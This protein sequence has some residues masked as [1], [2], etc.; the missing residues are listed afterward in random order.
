MKLKLFYL[1]KV[2]IISLLLLFGI[3][4]YFIFL[5]PGNKSDCA[6]YCRYIKLESIS[7]DLIQR[8]KPILIIDT[9]NT[10]DDMVAYKKSGNLRNQNPDSLFIEIKKVFTNLE[11]AT[12]NDFYKKNKYKSLLDVKALSCSI[13]TR[14]FLS[15]FDHSPDT[16]KLHFSQLGFN[17]DRTQAMVY[18]FASEESLSDFSLFFYKYKFG[19]W[20]KEYEINVNRYSWLPN[21]FPRENEPMLI[22]PIRN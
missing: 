9:T 11:I 10:L 22:P 19:I 13:K 14:N 6:V 8:N 4:I 12:L 20:Y 21:V 17:K 2:I 7:F 15:Y 5:I 3:L 16:I 1:L 18:V